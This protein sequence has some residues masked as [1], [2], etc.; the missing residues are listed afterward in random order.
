MKEKFSILVPLYNTPDVFLHDMIDSV[1]NQTYK[2]W[3]L[4]LADASDKEHSYVEDIVNEYAQKDR[5]IKYAKL[6]QNRGISENTNACIDISTGNYMVLLDHDD[7]LDKRALKEVARVISKTGADFIYSDEAKFT[8]SIEDWFAPNYKP[9]FSKYELRAHNYI[10]HLTVYSRELLEQAGRYRKEC[11]GSQDHDMVLRLTERAKRIEHIPKILYYWRVHR[12]SVSAGVENKSYAIDA[13]KKAVLDQVNRSG[14]NAEIVTHNPFPLLYDVQYEVK[15]NP[16]VMIVL[17]GEGNLVELKRCIES[18]NVAAGYDNYEFLIFTKNKEI[19]IS[20][21]LLSEIKN[22]HP[23]EILYGALNDLKTQEILAEKWQDYLLFMNYDCE[24]ESV[25]FLKELLM[26]AQQEDIGFVGPKIIGLDDSVKQAGVALS[27]EV[28]TGIVCRFFGEAVSS[29]GYEAGLCHVREVTALSQDCMMISAEKFQEIGGFSSEYTWYAGVDICLCARKKSYKNVWTPYAIVKKHTEQTKPKLCEIESFR[30]KWKNLYKKEDPYYNRFIRYDID[31]IHDKNSF[32][33]L[34]KKSV[35]YLCDDGING[36]F[37]RIKVYQGKGG[38]HSSS[39]VS[40]APQKVNDIKTAYK[41][42]LFINGC[43]PMV[44]HPPRYRVTHQREQLEACN[45]STGEVYY[46]ELNPD[47]VNDYRSFIF[48]RC[49]YTDNV[50]ELIKRAKSLDRL[51]LF[52]IDDLVV[53]TKYTDTI[54]YVISLNA[55]EKAVYDDGVIRMGKTLKLCDGAITTTERLAE[56]ISHYVPEVFI[57]RNVASER[58]YELSEQAIFERDVVP[59][60]K[61]EELPTNLSL[62]QYKKIKEEGKRRVHGGIRIGYFSG[63]ITHNE[64]FDMIRPAIIRIL[65]KYQNTKLCLVGELDLPK[66]L[67]PYKNRIISTP[68]VKWEKLPSLI[69]SVDIN[70]APITLSIF[71]EAKSENKWTEAALVKVPTVASAVGAFSVAIEDGETGLLC[72]NEEDWYYALEKLVT[73]GDERKRLG[74][75]AYR[76]VVKNYITTYTGGKLAQYIKNKRSENYAFVIPSVEISGG[77]MVA[78]KHASILKKKGADVFLINDNIKTKKEVEFDGLKFPVLSTKNTDFL[79]RIDKCI[80]TM[81]STMEF[82][83]RSINIGERY[84]LVQNYETDF[85]KPGNVLRTAA[86]KSYRP[87]VDMNFLTISKWVQS[88]LKERYDVDAQ[89]IPNGI[90]LK[91][92]KAE[93]RNFSG[94]VRILIEG[95]C[96]VD[97]K[98]VDESFRI[99][100]CLDR[101]KFE[102]WYVSYNAEPKDWYRPDRFFKKVPYDEMPSIYGQCHILLKSSL[103]ESFSYPPLEMMATGGYV[104]VVPND[105]NIEYLEDEKNCLMYPAGEF[106]MAVS[107]IKRIVSD[108]ELQCKLYMNG[109]ETAQKRSWEYV[110]ADIEKVY[111]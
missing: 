50:G 65:E 16:A 109:I 12:E 75:N 82:L 91:Q 26:M 27:K 34:C 6:S 108:N 30:E 103:L 37:E 46:E 5:R 22:T 73:D 14:E 87:I 57:N 44:P 59:A 63:S 21:I 99:V 110:C 33:T 58:M 54:P 9:D 88:W 11:D 104:V 45:F 18:I 36:L 24:A 69:A 66:E 60:L 48:F 47:V 55:E 106:E 53:D 1:Q 28:P 80:A 77:I 111:R 100:Q 42:I 32:S 56:E 96:A 13:A 85:Y 49:P 81:W 89:Y 68:F 10:C 51:V 84:Y 76:Y 90:N 64:D 8:T 62:S 95:D 72:K 20:K 40:Y 107:Q 78:L 17:H 19:D 23:Y 70:L 101:S 71:N 98:N 15:G 31:Q 25:E 61:I 2:N 38:D 83:E 3:E 67:Q 93:R 7:V 97:Y 29:Y 41:D 74:E 102:V 39:H 4:C 79:G 92:F 105:G 43:A 52:D 94:K 35:Q 86:E